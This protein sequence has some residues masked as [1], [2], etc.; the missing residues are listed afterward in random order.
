MLLVILNTLLEVG[1]LLPLSL[2][3]PTTTPTSP[4]TY[5]VYTP[6]PP[7]TYYVYT[8]TPP[9]TYYVYTPTPPLTYYVYTPTPPPPLLFPWCME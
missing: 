7:L 2:P 1:G 9:L 6:T 8:P 4:L 5:Y 3:L